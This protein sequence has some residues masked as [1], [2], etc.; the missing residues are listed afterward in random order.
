MS[1]HPNIEELGTL[2]VADVDIS[3]RDFCSCDPHLD[4]PVPSRVHLPFET[5]RFSAPT[6]HLA[7]PVGA[8]IYCRCADCAENAPLNPASVEASFERM[9]V[10][11]RLLREQNVVRA[12]GLE[13]SRAV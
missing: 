11:G 6:I 4:V 9:V 8:R 2:Y 3:E 1:F 7:M 12:E 10:P 5:R 13:P